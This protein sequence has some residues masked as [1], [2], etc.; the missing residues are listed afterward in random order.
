[1]RRPVAA[2]GRCSN[3]RRAGYQRSLEPDSMDPSAVWQN[4]PPLR[5][6][7]RLCDLRGRRSKFCAVGRKIPRELSEQAAAQLNAVAGNVYM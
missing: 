4:H 6:T 3:L 2:A 1:M 7:N 5:R